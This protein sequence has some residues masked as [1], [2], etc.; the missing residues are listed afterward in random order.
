MVSSY[1]LANWL[2]VLMSDESESVIIDQWWICT[3][4][5]KEICQ[6]GAMSHT[7]F[8]FA[9]EQI[10]FSSREAFDFLLG[11]LATVKAIRQDGNG[12]QASHSPNGKQSRHLS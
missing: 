1:F 10:R 11:K 8:H 12:S 3:W 7:S 2:M 6:G 5:L 9:H 4:V